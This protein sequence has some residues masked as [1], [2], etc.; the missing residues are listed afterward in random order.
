[1]A[2]IEAIPYLRSKTARRIHNA[3]KTTVG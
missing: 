2:S 1:L 3:A